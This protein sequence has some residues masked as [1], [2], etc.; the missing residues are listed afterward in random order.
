MMILIAS[1]HPEIQSALRLLVERIPAVSRVGTNGGLV[2]LLAQCAQSC[3]DLI[4]FDLDLLQAGR[5][6]SQSLAGLL[7]VLQRLCPGCQVMVMSSRFEAQQEALA[8]GA[9]GFISKTDPPD[10]VCSGI[11]RVLEK[12]LIKTKSI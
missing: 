1:P 5:T 6:A 7:V 11:V 10:E 3:P 12:T 2:Q 8:A 9:G 4:L